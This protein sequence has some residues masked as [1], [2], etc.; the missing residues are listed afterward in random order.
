MAVLLQNHRILTMLL[1][2]TCLIKS[3]EVTD[4]SLTT[5][6]ATMLAYPQLCNY[7]AITFYTKVNAINFM[8]DVEF[9]ALSKSLFTAGYLGCFMRSWPDAIFNESGTN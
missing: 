2:Y 8:V 7:H 3:A 5:G 4:L 9:L 1:T 6:L